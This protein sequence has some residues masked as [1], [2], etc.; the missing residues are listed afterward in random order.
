MS[1]RGLE[2]QPRADGQR[3]ERQDQKR[4][5]PGQRPF[6]KHRV[7]QK[8]H[9][10]NIRCQ[11]QRLGQ[12]IADLTREYR[13]DPVCRQLATGYEAGRSEVGIGQLPAIGGQLVPVAE[14]N[15]YGMG[16]FGALL[17]KL[18]G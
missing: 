8:Y 9:E 1:G 4:D 14:N 16:Q 18:A 11:S 7:V 15:D 17:S 12:G 13:L 5:S 6:H 2:Q 10:D 3:R